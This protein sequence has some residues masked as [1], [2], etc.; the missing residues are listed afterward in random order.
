MTQFVRANKIVKRIKYHLK[1]PF[2]SQAVITSNRAPQDSSFLELPLEIKL[3]IWKRLP[4]V[5]DR[6]SLALTCK[7]NAEMFEDIKDVRLRDGISFLLPKPQR[8]TRVHRL[9][10]LVRLQTW[11]P[12]DWR[13]CYRCGQYINLSDPVN[14]GPWGGD[15]NIVSNGLA[16]DRAMREGPRCALCIAADHVEMTRHKNTY[17]KYV[18]LANSVR[19]H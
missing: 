4:T 18:K 11:V 6:L 13:L 5:A 14:A 3:N 17:K 9:Q 12:D 16:T 7:E 15:T 2:I 8:T 10:V 19:L 1:E